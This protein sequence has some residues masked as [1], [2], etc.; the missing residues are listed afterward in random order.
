MFLFCQG[1]YSELYKDQFNFKPAH[2]LMPEMLLP[3]QSIFVFN[4]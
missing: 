1:F 2:I 4:Q 3:N